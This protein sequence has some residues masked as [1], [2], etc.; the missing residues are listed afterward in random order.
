MNKAMRVEITFP[1]MKAAV[2]PE[3]RKPTDSVVT[4]SEAVSVEVVRYDLEPGTIIPEQ[5]MYSLRV[6]GEGV[7][8]VDGAEWQRMINAFGTGTW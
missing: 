3:D 6:N 7:L 5:Q 2:K 8:V 4:R 1:V